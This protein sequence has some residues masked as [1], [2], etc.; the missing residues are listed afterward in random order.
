[1]TI[2]DVCGSEIPSIYSEC[3]VCLQDAAKKRFKPRNIRPESEEK[4]LF[5]IRLNEEE[6]KIL[7]Q[8]KEVFD[9]PSDSTA[10][11]IGCFQGFR[12]LQNAFPIDFLKW[13][14]SRDRQRLTDKRFK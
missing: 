5:T 6:R 3:Q 1:M 13:I 4:L 8:I 2:C 7:D 10:I 9:I 14:S 12:V 11:K